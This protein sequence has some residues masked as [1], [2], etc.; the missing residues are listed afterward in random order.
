VLKANPSCRVTGC[1][2]SATALRLFHLAAQQAGVQPHRIRTFTLDAASST[3]DSSGKVTADSSADSSCDSTASIAGGTSRSVTN[4]A[5]PAVPGSA[6]ACSPLAGLG[7]DSLLLVFTLS[8][9][10]PAA[11]AAAL[12]HAYAAL[13]PGGLLLFR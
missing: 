2:I 8:A 5:E 4:S 6:G 1:D 3:A 10:P 9:L 11:H 13:R 12:T 7:A